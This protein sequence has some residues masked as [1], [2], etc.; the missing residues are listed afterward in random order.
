MY[1]DDTSALFLAFQF[2]STLS[3]YEAEQ[4]ALKSSLDA[5]DQLLNQ[6]N[7]SEY[8]IIFVLCFGII[9]LVKNN[10]RIEFRFFK[11]SAEFD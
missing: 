1:L 3:H 11:N 7:F 6:V 4:Q 10:I 9:F 2:S 8:K 5:N